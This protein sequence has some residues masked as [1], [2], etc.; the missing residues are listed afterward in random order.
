MAFAMCFEFRS[1]CLF[2]GRLVKA[3]ARDE[4][5]F[6]D[7]SAFAHIV[8]EVGDPYSAFPNALHDADGVD[9]P[10]EPCERTLG[11]YF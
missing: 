10:S 4:S 7:R 2:W 3:R 9:L 11:H 8:G 1:K 6:L 5:F